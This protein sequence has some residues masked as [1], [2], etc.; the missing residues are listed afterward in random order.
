MSLTIV[1][2][3]SGGGVITHAF[4]K[5]GAE[6]VFGNEICRNK[7]EQMYIPNHG[8]RIIVA[9]IQEVDPVQFGIEP[10]KLDIY[11]ASPPCTKFSRAQKDIEGELDI[12]VAKAVIRHIEYLRPKA[13]VIENVENYEGSVSYNILFNGFKRLGYNVQKFK[14]NSADYGTPQTRKR[15]YVIA[16]RSDIGQVPP[17]PPTHTEFPQPTLFGEALKPWVGWL[18]AVADLIPDHPCFISYWDEAGELQ[19]NIS[20]GNTIRPAKKRENGLA[21]WHKKRV[22]EAIARGKLNGFFDCIIDGK[23]SGRE[24]TIKSG[25]EPCYTLVGSAQCESHWLR[26]FMV[27]T[28]E[29]SMKEARQGSQPS[30]TITGQ[31]ISAA[32]LR[33]VLI[34]GA[35]AGNNTPTV[36]MGDRPGVTLTPN[37]Y[38]RGLFANQLKSVLISGGNGSNTTLRT[39]DC[40]GLTLTAR[41][42]DRTLFANQTNLK[43]ASVDEKFKALIDNCVIVKFDTRMLARLQ[44]LDDSYYLCSNNDLASE[45]IGNGVAVQVAQAIYRAIELVIKK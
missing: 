32:Q 45:C 11:Q 42:W 39:G 24:I 6:I 29:F 13:I 1:T 18:E 14:L 26:A 41:N 9:P 12:S 21:D 10:G 43:N 2:V 8:N 28:Q 16:M 4:K 17:I 30:T 20:E 3:F 7:V 38:P 35:N 25:N 5:V 22:K 27:T 37:T 44:G 19:W 36:R 34:P 15:L 31:R 23:N 40:P 33:A